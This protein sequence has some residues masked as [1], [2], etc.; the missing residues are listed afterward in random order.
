MKINKNSDYSEPKS[1]KQLNRFAK[2]AKR[3]TNNVFKSVAKSNIIIFQLVIRENYFED[4]EAR[5][6]FR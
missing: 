1:K 3:F 6:S 2:F 4:N 5:K